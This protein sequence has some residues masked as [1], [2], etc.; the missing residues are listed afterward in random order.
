MSSKQYPEEFRAEAVKQIIDRGYS[1]Q[2]VSQRLGVS[3]HS[4]DTCSHHLS[5]VIPSIDLVLNTATVH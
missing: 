5:Q 3:I 4:L 2:E 1:V